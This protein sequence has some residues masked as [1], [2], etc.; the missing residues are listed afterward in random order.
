[1]HDGAFLVGP[2]PTE[3]AVGIQR[4]G[5]FAGILRKLAGIH[6]LAVQA[7]LGC[8]RTDRYRIIAGDDLDRNTLFY[9]EFHSFAGVGTHLLLEYDQCRRGNTSRR[10]GVIHR[11]VGDAQ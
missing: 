3:G 9:K 5:Q 7:K 11:H 2:H 6:R 1:M 10:A 8:D 4:I